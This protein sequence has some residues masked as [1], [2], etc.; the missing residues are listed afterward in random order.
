M[1]KKIQIKLSESIFG[2]L[3]LWKKWVFFGYMVKL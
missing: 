1:L 2:S 3:F